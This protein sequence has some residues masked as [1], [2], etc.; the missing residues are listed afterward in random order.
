MNKDQ[1]KGRADQVKG[2]VKDAAG[3]LT[4]DK[5]LDIE[6]K[7]DQVK[8]KAQADLGDAKERAKRKIDKA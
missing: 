3:D 6:G 7:A 1:L 5:R 2:K 8:G 4:G